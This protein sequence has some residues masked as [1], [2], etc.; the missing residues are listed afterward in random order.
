MDQDKKFSKSN[1]SLTTNITVG[2]VTFLIIV[3]MLPFSQSV[4]GS[5]KPSGPENIPNSHALLVYAN[6]EQTDTDLSAQDIRVIEFSDLE[7]S[8]K[9][10]PFFKLSPSF[11]KKLSNILLLFGISG[12]IFF[13]MIAIF[14]REFSNQDSIWYI[15]LGF[16]VLLA[17]GII[18]LTIISKPMGLWDE[19]YVLASG[20]KNFSV[21]GI[22]GVPITGTKGL[23]ESSVDL[24]VVIFAGLLLF[25][26]K[27][28]EADTSLLISAIVLNSTLATFISVLLRKKLHLGQGK[29]IAVAFVLLLNPLIISTLMGGMPTVVAVFAWPLFGLA[30]YYSLVSKKY[31]YLVIISLFLLFVRWELGLIAS[32][33]CFTFY[34]VLLNTGVKHPVNEYAAKYKKNSILLA[35]L[36]ALLFLTFTRIQLFGSF[37]PSGMLGKSVGLDSAYLQ[38]GLEYFKITLIDSMWLLVM[39]IMASF[40][41]F[42]LK[43]NYAKAYLIS[44]GVLTIPAI[45][46]LPGGKDYFLVD[47][48]RYTLPST[49]AILVL[50]I[51]LLGSRIY[52]AFPP[53]FI[54]IVSYVLIFVIQLPGIMSIYN[55]KSPDQVSYRLNCLAKA[56]HSLRS[57]FPEVQSLATAEVNTIAFFADVK[58]T[59]LIGFVDPRTASV[60]KSPLSPGDP[61]HRKSNYQIISEDKPDS[62]YLYEAADC[63]ESD[64]SPEQ[65]RAKWNELINSDINRFRV[66][67]LKEVLSYYTPVT[68]VIPNQ[69]EV[70]FLMKNNFVSK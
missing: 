44:L 60:P 9:D 64:F 31:V 3:V 38:S 28:L 46:F 39:L 59:D 41:L 53:R 27:S 70:R 55:L 17:T 26:I 42:Y 34:S 7:M 35:P 19:T 2:V 67:N 30:F 4:I 51:S 49:V 69:I 68:I 65:D 36:V 6:L 63:S 13:G 12:I 33:T 47:W 56:G 57:V 25:I 16:W 1:M 20:A 29:S 40:C 23:A 22:P 45:I 15:K 11:I 58:L 62:I 48:S 8:N 18:V 24:L 32:L 10:M 54:W 37:A 66:G 14:S 50:S 21:S 61:F 5:F 43:K 52:S